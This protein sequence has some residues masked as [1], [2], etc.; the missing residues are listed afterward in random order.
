MILLV[1]DTSG[2][3]CS[4]ALYDS[5]A[6][7]L[8]ASRT[9]RL[10]KGHAER[11]PGMVEDILGEARVTLQQVGLIG[12]TVGPGSFTGIRTGVAAARGFALALGVPAVGISTLAVLAADWRDENG[13]NPVVA[14]IDAKRGEIYAQ[15]FGA[16]GHPLGEPQALD[17]DGFRDL[18][19]QAGG[20]VTGSAAGL[21]ADPPRAG[22][23]DAFPALALARL[24]VAAPVG[25]K[26]KPLYLRAPDAKPQAGFALSR[27]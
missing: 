3:D 4:A 21:L 7:C 8:M 24:S 14:A 6:G 10:G 20:A 1:L 27:T 12:V 16:D 23:G 15:A 18:V 22:D 2:V 11:L 25:D 19:R 5:A 26:P 13:A 17:L 9:E